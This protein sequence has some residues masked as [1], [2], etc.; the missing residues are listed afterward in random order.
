[1]SQLINSAAAASRAAEFRDQL[2]ERVLIADG[3]MGTMLYTKGVFIN[4]CYD[5]L[6]LPAP[7]M[8]RELHEEYVK[9]GAQ[10]VET[11]TFGANRIRLAGYGLAETGGRCNGLRFPAT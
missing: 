3:A 2:S 10:I 6:N 7:A 1:M 11:N 5:E 4:R 8:V 9:A